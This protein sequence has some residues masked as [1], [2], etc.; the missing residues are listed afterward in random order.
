MRFA[1]VSAERT[2]GA[3]RANRCR[4]NRGVRMR[5]IL[6]TEGKGPVVVFAM[7]AST[8]GAVH[9]RKVAEV[10]VMTPRTTA[11]AVEHPHMQGRLPEEADR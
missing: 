10:C 4:E 7:R 2:V 1:A 8:K 6:A 5:S 3:G 9:T 11:D